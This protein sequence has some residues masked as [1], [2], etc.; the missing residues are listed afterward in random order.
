MKRENKAAWMGRLFLC[1]G[2]Q[3]KF[4]NSRSQV[5][6]ALTPSAHSTESRANLTF[7]FA[8]YSSW[9]LIRHCLFAS[10]SLP[11]RLGV[12]CRF[13]FCKLA[14]FNLR[15]TPQ[16]KKLAPLS[17]GSGAGGEGK[18]HR[19]ASLQDAVFSRSTARWCRCAYH[20]LIAGIPSG[21]GQLI[22]ASYQES[23]AASAA[24]FTCYGQL[25][26]I[27]FC[28]TSACGDIHPT[29][30]IAPSLFLRPRNPICWTIRALPT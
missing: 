15:L 11:A 27:T 10:A 21:C 22:D 6:S 3:P 23:R 26:Q 24:S 2:C 4:T 5:G 8:S 25:S 14:R 7:T 13:E 1:M 16:L 20:R 17:S 18:R 19:L 30:S 29:T 12:F 9:H 28:A